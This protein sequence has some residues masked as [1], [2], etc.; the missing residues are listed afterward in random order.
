MTGKLPLTLVT[1]FLG[2]G[3]TT[4]LT[5]LAR[6]H[7]DRSL[8]FVVNEFG[9]VD[10]DGGRLSRDLAH[11]VPIPGGS[12]FCTC[13][14][15]TFIER[16]QAVADRAEALGLDAVVVEA[17]GIADPRVAGRMLS[18]SGLDA[19]FLLTNVI[20][21]VDPGNFEKLLAT[22]PN[23][24]SQVA[25]ATQVVINK[26][27]RYDAQTVTRTEQLVREIA[28]MVSLQRT[29]FGRVVVDLF[30]DRRAEPIAGEY[31]R[32]ADP[33][34]TTTVLRFDRPVPLSAVRGLIGAV[35]EDLYRAKGTVLT[36]AG[37]IAIDA[38]A[39]GVDTRPIEPLSDPAGEARSELVLIA[40]GRSRGRLMAATAPLA[41]VAMAH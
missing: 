10:V 12:I 32:C 6:A 20:A 37:P 22:L 38:S 29:C 4:C 30:G 26:T 24:R 7:E 33:N 5:H 17:S 25:A 40:H 14:V 28:P 9:A 19:R 2:A 1:G 34:Y 23:V 39:S 3:K 18:E 16:L 15:S 13:L 21:L 27:D 35:G 8:L 31:A 41:G 11:V 36:D